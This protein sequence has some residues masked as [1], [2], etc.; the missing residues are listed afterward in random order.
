MRKSTRLT[1]IVSLALIFAAPSLPA[2]AQQGA[3]QRPTSAAAASPLTGGAP[4]ALIGME[5]QL[6]ATTT[7]IQFDVPVARH[8]YYWWRGNCYYRN[9]SGN[10][11]PVAAGYCS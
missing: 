11:A 8:L 7:T 6:K 1:H 4:G 3:N 5:G 9:P 10:Y 2:M